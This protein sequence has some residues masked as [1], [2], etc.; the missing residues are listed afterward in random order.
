[1]DE[2]DTM[3]AMM[4]TPRIRRGG[5]GRFAKPTETNAS[6]RT[7]VRQRLADAIEAY[8]AAIDRRD[9]CQQADQRLSNSI[10][11]ELQPAVRKARKALEEAKARE[12]ARLVNSVL[13]GNGD[14]PRTSTTEAQITLDRVEQA[15]ADARKAREL[16]SQ[17]A[18]S[19]EHA[20]DQA[21]RELGAAV[22][23][24]VATSGERQALLAEFY[25]CA[26]RTLR[27]AQ[28]LRSSGHRVD[29]H[30][31]PS[32]G[33]R[34]HVFYAAGFV[35]DGVKFP[36]DPDW[37]RALAELREDADTQLPALPPEE[38]PEPAVAA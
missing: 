24:V 8:G 29:G 22:K 28:S 37:T 9:R 5:D 27:M 14:L 17:E 38:G 10:F 26:S 3:A 2:A 23:A 11:D 25:R 35:G 15:L 7:P 13:G 6:I 4:D 16:I 31:L 1:M 33:L 34:L 32:T 18:H 20:A 12:P 36:L 30:E 21:E 19:A